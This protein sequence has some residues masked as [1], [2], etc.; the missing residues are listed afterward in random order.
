MKAGLTQMHSQSDGWQ[1]PCKKAAST[2]GCCTIDQYQTLPWRKGCVPHTEESRTRFGL[3]LLVLEKKRNSR[4]PH[5]EHSG[6]AAEAESQQP[7]MQ[8][9][10]RQ[11]L[12]H[13]RV[14]IG[15]KEVG[16]DYASWTLSKP[17]KVAGI[18]LVYLG[19]PLGCSTALHYLAAKMV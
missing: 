19:D 9:W 11:E 16:C 7:R 6:P 12:L 4:I 2:Q 17:M 10:Y 8:H 3:R 1:P 15:M 18:I 13:M 5:L 14:S